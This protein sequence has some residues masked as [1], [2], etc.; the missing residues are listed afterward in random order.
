MKLNI[1]FKPGAKQAEQAGNYFS[2]ITS[3]VV[4]EVIS[5]MKPYQYRFEP[6]EGPVLTLRF[7][8][9]SEPDDEQVIRMIPLI[10]ALNADLRMMLGSPLPTQQIPE[11]VTEWLTA[12]CEMPNFFVE[13]LHPR[14]AFTPKEKVELSVAMLG[15]HLRMVSSRSF[16]LVEQSAGLYGLAVGGH[17]SYLFEEAEE[18]QH[19]EVGK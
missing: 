13:Q 3:D 16:M 19:A 17:G 14:T 4:D 11:M 6:K 10:H 1:T 5:D 12:A 2:Q 8:C 7:W 9:M 15:G 18:A